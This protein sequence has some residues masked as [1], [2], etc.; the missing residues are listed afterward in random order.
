M[1]PLTRRT[2]S[3]TAAFG[4][5]EGRD[6]RSD[7]LVS[8]V[9]S[10]VSPEV[11]PRSALYPPVLYTRMAKLAQVMAMMRHSVHG[12]QDEPP[13]LLAPPTWSPRRRP[14]TRSLSDAGPFAPTPSPEAAVVV[15]LMV[16]LSGEPPVPPKLWACLFIRGLSKGIYSPIA[17]ISSSQAG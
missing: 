14:L 13:R 15:G 10:F 5:S 11:L 8:E 2:C 9:A 4:P 3:P 6:G 12:S 7:L 17:I 1:T 16:D